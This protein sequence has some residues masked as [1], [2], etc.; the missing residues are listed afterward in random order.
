M[1]P[2]SSHPEEFTF[3][4]PQFTPERLAD[5]AEITQRLQQYSQG[6]DR[7]QYSLARDMFH[8]DA[9]ISHAGYEG[10]PAGLF[11]IVEARNK[12][13]EFSFHALLNISIEFGSED[14]A[15]TETY[16]L[17]WLTELSGV[18]EIS[19]PNVE[20]GRTFERLSA[21]RYNDRFTRRN[22]EWRS[23]ERIT[24]IEGSLVLPSPETGRFQFPPTWKGGRRDFSDPSYVLRRKA[25]LLPPLG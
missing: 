24:A 22:G 5:R 10:D 17:S 18:G 1:W 15:V 4:I 7:R 3:M 13:L 21:A 8:P 25:G 20:P 23:E 9:H 11:E 19:P 16:S 2:L 12:D 14:E 6:V